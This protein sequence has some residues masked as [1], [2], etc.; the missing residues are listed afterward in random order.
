MTMRTMWRQ[1]SVAV[2]G[3]AIGRPPS[4][5][6]V[7]IQR[8]SAASSTSRPSP[9]ARA[10]VELPRRVEPPSPAHVRDRVR[11]VHDRLGGVAHRARTEVDQLGQGG[12][13]H[14]RVHRQ[15]LTAAIVALALRQQQ[16]RR[17]VRSPASHR[18]ARGRQLERGQVRPDDRRQRLG[19]RR[20]CPA[21][22]DHPRG[23]QRGELVDRALDGHR[24]GIGGVRD[25][26]AQRLLADQQ[27][28]PL[29]IELDGAV[30]RTRSPSATACMSS[31]RSSYSSAAVVHETTM[32]SSP[33]GTSHCS[34]QTPP[35]TLST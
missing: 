7:S 17:A 20:V 34:R 19:H 6:V 13:E 21:A 10:V 29:G 30:H 4:S 24:D 9:P 25:E 23:L 2:T 12:R 31:K 33:A 18:L 1:T 5:P 35:C 16:R 32:P 11:H 3:H 8:P 28:A 14:R 22:R 15:Q 27:P 26:H